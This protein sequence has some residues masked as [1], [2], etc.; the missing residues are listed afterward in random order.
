MLKDTMSIVIKPVSKSWLSS[1]TESN[2][3]ELLQTKVDHQN[4]TFDTRGDKVGSE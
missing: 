2:S 4:E 1:K 3:W